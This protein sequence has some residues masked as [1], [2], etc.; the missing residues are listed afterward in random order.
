MDD[1]EKQPKPASGQIT[2][3]NEEDFQLEVLESLFLDN[4]ID[5]VVLMDI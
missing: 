1:K 5:D 3:E 2:L 4:D